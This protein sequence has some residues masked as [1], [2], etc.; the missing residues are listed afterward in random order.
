MTFK[1]HLWRYLSDMMLIFYCISFAAKNWFYVFQ[2]IEYTFIG[3]FFS[4]LDRFAA[5]IASYNLQQQV[6]NI[7]LLEL[8]GPHHVL[9]TCV[10]P[11]ELF[12]NNPTGDVIHKSAVIFSLVLFVMI[13]SD[14]C[15]LKICQLPVHHFLHW[16]LIPH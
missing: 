13:Y 10:W 3:N 15:G 2:T 8:G 1:W 4:S 9:V 16:L 14:I 11:Q 6:C 5:F 7:F 12:F